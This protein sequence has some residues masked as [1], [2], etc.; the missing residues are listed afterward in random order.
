MIHGQFRQSNEIS[1]YLDNKEH[2]D[3]RKTDKLMLIL[4]TAHLPLIYFV[5][6]WS[7][8]TALPG[9]IAATL[10]V[11]AAWLVY[12][13]AQGS[14]LSRAVLASGFMVM[15]MIMIFQ[16]LGRLEMHFHVF[17]ALAL[18][19]IWHDVKVLLVAAGVIAVH[20]LLSVPIQQSGFEIG[21]IPFM[22][23]P[24]ECD[25]A[26]FLLHAIFVILETGIL[27]AITMRLKHQI[28]ISH[29]VMGNLSFVAKTKNLD[30]NLDRI[31]TKNPED[32][33]LVQIL[34]DFFELVRCTFRDFK[35]ASAQLGRIS[36]ES[37][38]NTRQNQ[39]VL[40]EQTDNIEHVK[41][42]VEQV[43]SMVQEITQL[44]DQAS[45]T[46]AQSKQM[47][48]ESHALVENTVRLTTE[49]I[50]QLND[51]K[52]VVDKLA[53]DTVEIASTLNDIR[54]IA[55]Q[56]NLLA[57]NAAIEAARAGEQGR[58]FAVVADEVRTLA[59][60]S[61][62]ATQEIDSV[63]EK[64]KNASH[65]AVEAMLAGQERSEKTI[66]AAEQTQSLLSQASEETV[67][68][69][70]LSN[71]INDAVSKQASA[72]DQIKMDINAITD[73]NQTVQQCSHEA[74][75]HATEVAKLA[76]QLNMAVGE[77]QIEK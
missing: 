48:H 66:E 33:E 8:S 65:R 72:S 60:R 74:I 17:F 2:S 15:S 61:Q 54:G 24:A 7:N 9:G 64:L 28:D 59:Q 44:T 58:G 22:V 34:T 55:E 29:V 1:A 39:T 52:D 41:E 50:T 73:F 12:S 43:S 3:M 42:S 21:E 49:L 53:D 40:N 4:L 69:D 27:I 46:A 16:Q 14:F 32:K 57:L 20:H 13:V 37:H 68:I 19:P 26:T 5:V 67:K 76:D 11:I 56:T 77:W 47:T 62:E 18:M 70:N 10:T 51:S 25:W 75:D 45:T 6:P 63:I 35:Q 36:G 71:S 38:D 23:Y 30:V 31:P